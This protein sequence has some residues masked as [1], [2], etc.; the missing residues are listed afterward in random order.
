MVA[1]IDIVSTE[2][3]ACADRIGP[4]GARSLA[5]TA[6]LP[7]LT[8]IKPLIPLNLELVEIEVAR[9]GGARFSNR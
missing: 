5:L 7:G 9:G 3:R 6:A 8:V 1:G 4:F 2:R